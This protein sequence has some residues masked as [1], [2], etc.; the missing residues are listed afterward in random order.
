[1]KNKKV[2]VLGIGPGNPDYVIPAV[3]EAVEKCDC[4]V[5]AKRNLLLFENKRFENKEKIYIKDRF[6]YVMDFIKENRKNKNIAV[7]VSGDPGFHSILN[8]IRK[9]LKKDEYVVIPGISSVQMAFAKIGDSWEDAKFIS[10]H[11]GENMDFVDDVK[12]NDK[13]FFLTDKDFSPDVIAGILLKNHMDNRKVF[14]L[15]NISYPNEK[16]T[17][18]DL[19]NLKNMKGFE[20]CV[21]IIKK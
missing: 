4:L 10:C 5:G 17:E 3:R 1:M 21:M 13:V 16:I 9:S 14:V 11:G 20:L 12:K 15:E 18:T 19:E 2:Y 7:I 8:L 6:D